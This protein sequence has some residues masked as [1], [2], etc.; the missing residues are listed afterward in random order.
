MFVG[1]L[2]RK[3]LHTTVGRSSSDEIGHKSIRLGDVRPLVIMV[4]ASVMLSLSGRACPC[5]AILLHALIAS[6]FI[7]TRPTKSIHVLLSIVRP[8]LGR[9]IPEI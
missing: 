8:G 2:G 4:T 5:T 9:T 7:P 1:H 3:R 6:D